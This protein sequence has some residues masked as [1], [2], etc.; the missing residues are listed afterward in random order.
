MNRV[1]ILCAC[2]LL[3]TTVIHA[4]T[5]LGFEA[6][7]AGWQKGNDTDVVKINS[8]NSHSGTACAMLQSAGS[9]LYQKISLGQLA[10]MQYNSHVKASDKGVEGYTFLRFYNAAG[11]LLLEYKIHPKFTDAYQESGNYTESPPGTDYIAIGVHKTSSEGVIY[12]DDFTV[13]LNVGEPAVKPKPAVNLDQYLQPFWKGDTVY[14]ETVLMYSI[15]GRPATSKL[16]YMPSKIISVKSFDLKTEFANNTDYSLKGNV[17]TRAAYSA[18]PYRADTS[19]SAKDLSW[20]NLQS[21][22]VAVTY[23]HKDKWTGPVTTYKATSLPT[24]MA[25]LTA[26]KPLTIVAYGMSITRGMDVSGYD[27]VAPYMPPYVNLFTYALQQSFGYNDITLYNAG[28]PGSRVDWAAQ[29]AET[30]INPLHPD[31]VILDFG[32]NDFWQYSPTQFKGFIQTIISKIKAANPAVEFLLL[33]NMKF[34]PAYVLDSDKYKNFYTSN[35]AGYNTVLQ[36]LQGPGVVNLD[37]T[38][39][40]DYIYHHKKAKDCIVNPLHPNDYM[41]RWYAQG[42]AALFIVE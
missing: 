40:S 31:L 37:M 38:S 16:L 17:I 39:L 22:W 10:I 26:K 23:T 29:Y 35:L 13:E 19:F 4:Q 1:I 6:G 11:S 30:Y 27:N 18:M 2:I 41:A 33:S 5:N 12:A 25:K 42:M 14:N 21:Q 15:N 36:Q 9:E 24:A 7:L 20:Y 8:A 3:A 32:M 28:L 34:D